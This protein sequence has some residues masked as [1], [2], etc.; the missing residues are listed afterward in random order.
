MVRFSKREDE[1]RPRIRTAM[2]EASQTKTGRDVWHPEL[3]SEHTPVFSAD[4][5][6]GTALRETFRA[7]ARSVSDNLAS[8]DL[9]L[10]MW[11]V[12]R[13]LWET[14]GLSQVELAAKLEVTPAAVVGLVNV[15]EKAGL[16]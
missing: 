9:S 3:G 10:N 12:L 2:A 7:F 6:V 13:S 4:R 16:V 14:D 8:S 5:H 11:F 15:L 1:V